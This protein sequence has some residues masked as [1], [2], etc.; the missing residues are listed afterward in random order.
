MS[1]VY[2][3]ELCALARESALSLGLTLQNG[4]FLGLVGPQMETR[5]ETR[6]F[7]SW[8][9]DA[10]GMSTVLEVIAA[11]S[12]GLRVLGLS[13]LS[14]RNLPDCMAATSLEEI[15][16]VSGRSAQDLLRLIPCLLERL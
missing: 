6:M 8:G 12:L 3:E 13:V 5:A 9:A 4:V 10:V 2:D 16:R 15:I 7:R 11:R 1:A 14:N